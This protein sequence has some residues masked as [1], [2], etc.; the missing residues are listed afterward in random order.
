MPVKFDS[1]DQH[2]IAVV[3][4]L[5]AALPGLLIWH[6]PNQGKRNPNYVRKLKLMGLLPGVPDLCFL[7][8]YD[9]R[10]RFPVYFIEMKAKTGR[11]SQEQTDFRNAAIMRGA[12]WAVARN[13][14]EVERQLIKWGFKLHAR[15]RSI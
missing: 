9:N 15:V 10:G 4:F 7:P 12:G 11:L 6:T 2:H 1:E 3:A 5:E 8:H 14:E 13:V